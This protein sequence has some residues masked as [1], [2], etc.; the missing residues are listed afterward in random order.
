MTNELSSAEQ[1]DRLLT[2]Y[3]ISQAIYVAA[4]L[5]IADRLHDGPKSAGQLSSETGSHAEAL[6]RLLRALAS[7][8]IF[9]EDA[10]G[11]FGLT[12]QGALLQRDTAD[13]KWA[14]S[15]M[16]GEEHYNAWGQLLH[17]VQTGEGGFRKI[18]G[19]PIFDFLSEHPETGEIF[20]AAMTGIHGR[21]TAAVL[22]TYDFTNIQSLVDVGGGNGSQIVEILNRYPHMHGVVFDLPGVIQRARA[23]VEAAGLT[24][25][26]QLIAGDFFQSVPDGADAY[27]MRHIIHDW[28]DEQSVKILQ[29]CRDAMN[30]D[31][32]VLVVESV[33]APGNEPSFAKWL[34]LAM[35]VIPEGKERTAEQYRSLFEQA[36]LRLNRIVPTQLEVCVIEGVRA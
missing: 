25:R 30:A 1:L 10:E 32:K 17:S 23:R 19:K 13:S 29:N 34:D 22:E 8:G 7:I 3:W 12:P 24:V 28:D 26:C 2:G 15:V 35:L 11:R 4:K 18:H 5:E 14:L 6:Y 36:D 9:A 33:I 16:I 20:D 27:I 31:G 21:E